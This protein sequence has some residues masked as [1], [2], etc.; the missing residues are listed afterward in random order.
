MNSAWVPWLIL[1]FN[2]IVAVLIAG[3]RFVH[4]RPAIEAELRNLIKALETRSEGLA[5]ELDEL[6][7][8][9]QRMRDKASE[10]GS[11]LTEK[12]NGYFEKASVIE[13]K[14]AVLEARMNAVESII[15]LRRTRRGA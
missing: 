3:D 8:E 7:A 13:T 15:E 12:G 9:I 4:K 6:R 1:A 14:V 2:T 11:R 5:E 10:Q